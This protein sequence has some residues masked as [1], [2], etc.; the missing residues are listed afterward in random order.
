MKTAKLIIDGKEISVQIEET[1]LKKL[2]VKK[3]RWRAEAGDRYF[4]LW[5]DGDISANTESGGE[6]DNFR[7]LVG[8]YFQTKEQAE[9]Y[10]QFLQAVGEIKQYIVENG[11]EFKPDWKNDEQFKCYVYHGGDE[12]ERGSATTCHQ[13]SII[14]YLAEQSHAQAIIRDC[15]KQLEIIREFT[16][17]NNY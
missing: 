6:Y 4:Q 10:K 14:P 2:E 5:S 8:N 1:E 12:W 13:P 17:D 3:G 11:M 16:K 7:H 9:S 15:N